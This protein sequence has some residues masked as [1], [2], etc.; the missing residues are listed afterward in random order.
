MKISV[1]IPAY[2]EE[3]R[4]GKTLEEYCKFFNGLVKEKILDYQL[5]VVINNTKDKTEEIVKSYQKKFRKIKFLNFERGGKGFAITEG[6]KESLKGDFDLIGFVDADMATSP[7]AFYDLIEN[8][9]GYDGAIAS[10]SIRGAKTS[11]TFVRKITHRGF[12]L[13]TRFFF[14]FPYRD[15]QCG[16]K[17]FKREVIEKIND[18][19]NMTNWVYDVNLLYLCKR[20]GFRIKEVPTV[21]EDKSG[22]KVNVMKTTLQMFLGLVRLRLIYSVF[23]RI[24]GPVKF[25]LRFGNRLIN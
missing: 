7:E 5:L 8:I 1:I 23:E 2:N 19:I 4:I 20:G 24:L 9:N 25:I 11:F 16:A 6:F 13:F 14:F 17:I 15:T 3:K 18:K 22:S 12:N 10:R 21:W